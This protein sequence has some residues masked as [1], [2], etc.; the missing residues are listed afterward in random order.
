MRDHCPKPGTLTIVFKL[1]NLLCR[2]NK[3]KEISFNK[4]TMKE[5]ILSDQSNN[6]CPKTSD[7]DPA[8]YSVQL[9]PSAC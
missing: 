1:A 5:N 9:S 7:D 8:L 2:E 3:T 4:Q 6:L